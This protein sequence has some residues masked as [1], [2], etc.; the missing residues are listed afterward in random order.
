MRPSSP[1]STPNGNQA[2]QV[3]AWRTRGQATLILTDGEKPILARAGLKAPGHMGQTEENT[4]VIH[5]FGQRSAG[6]RLEIEFFRSLREIWHAGGGL[7]RETIVRRLK[8]DYDWKR[9][10]AEATAR[11]INGVDHLAFTT[12][13]WQTEE[14][15]LR[16]RVDWESFHR[17]TGRCLRS[18]DDLQAFHEYLAASGATGQGVSRSLQAGPLKLATRQFLRA[19]R[20][21]KWG[22]PKGGWGQK[23]IA[24]WLS[25][26]GYPTSLDDVKNAGRRGVKLAAGIVPSTEQ[27]M[28]FVAFVKTRFPGFD[29]GRMLTRKTVQVSDEPA[30]TAPFSQE[31]GNRQAA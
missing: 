11:P 25:A 10:V 26:G 19:L 7:D 22:L 6:S 28:R 18:L 9:Q 17:Q 8:M 21:G 12:R 27:V 23:E 16:C 14:D 31:G 1:A 13:P 3:L 4:W 24:Q 5:E 20:L 30:K 29:A 2:R 15:F